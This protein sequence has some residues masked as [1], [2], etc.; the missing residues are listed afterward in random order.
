MISSVL[1]SWRLLSGVN[2]LI[3][4]VFAF[5]TL[6]L[7]L[8]DIVAISLLGAIGA[9]AFGGTIN[10]PFVDLSAF[11]LSEI[12][13]YL[14]GLTA[15]LFTVKT[16][17][18][19]LLSKHQFKFLAR[20]E[21]EYSSIISRHV[22]GADLTTLKSHTRADLEWS[23]L[24]STENA[25]SG[26]V[27]RS[28]ILVSEAGLALLILS[29]FVYTDWFSALMVLV[30][31]IVVLGALDLFSNKL[32]KKT[33]SDVTLGSVSVVQAL[34]DSIVAIKEISVLSRL[35]FF[36]ERIRDARAR[37]AFGRATQNYIQ[38]IPRLVIELALIWGAIGFVVFQS[39]RNNGDLDFGLLSI[40]VVGGL[41]M[42]SALLP[43]QRA[44]MDLRFLAAQASG[45]QEIIREAIALKGQEI[46]QH[47]LSVESDPPQELLVRQ[48]LE[49]EVKD[50]SFSYPDRAS[51]EAV[52]QNINLVVYPGQTLALI[53]PSGA[54]KST[55]V[56]LILGLHEPSIG[57][58]LCGGIAPREFRNMNPGSI[59]YVPQKPGLVSGTVRDNVALGLKREE[60][61]EDSLV[62]ALRQAEIEDFVN[63]LPE[64]MDS[65]LGRHADSLSGGQIQRIG[66]AR[67]LYTRPKL[68]VLD[69]ATSALDPE[70]EASISV[71][72]AGL[73]QKPTVIIVAHR[74]STIQDADVVIAMDLGKIVA[75]GSF[76]DLQESSP[77]V[78]RFVSLMTIR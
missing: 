78:R 40:F 51:S 63:S 12:I 18:G 64:G 68:L 26:V 39:L 27:G 44:F 41:R 4:S 33:G 56:D 22:L 55:L 60:V 42:M 6:C 1:G 74:L 8:L 32:S 14:L 35:D 21:T 71:S 23:I 58:I 53:G 66:L 47:T 7:N 49:V 25:F 19:V 5:G 13:A 57:R 43:L 75:T 77:L 3:L 52:L 73:R 48:A 2:R 46:E 50:V 11:E 72:L 29:L 62:E 28:L 45:A 15:A 59:G 37:V 20:V 38:A 34:V 67:A 30:Y 70:T 76:K 54:G 9:I 69:E 31:F 10:F 65:S 16:V 36:L 61:D 17:A 24:R